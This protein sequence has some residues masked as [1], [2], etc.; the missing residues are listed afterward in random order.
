[1]AKLL[2]NRL[3]LLPVIVLWLANVLPGN[4]QPGPR[5]NLTPTPTTGLS[6][7]DPVVP[8]FNSTGVGRFTGQAASAYTCIDTCSFGYATTTSPTALCTGKLLLILCH[9]SN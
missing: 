6:L 1:M 3:Y 7:A 5:A 8:A 4:A 9:R 2:V